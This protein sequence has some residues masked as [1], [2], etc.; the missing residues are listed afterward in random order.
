[1][2]L[3]CYFPDA[4]LFQRDVFSEIS[5]DVERLILSIKHVVNTTLSGRDVVG[6]ADIK[7]KLD[8]KKKKDFGE[9]MNLGARAS[10]AVQSTD[11]IASR[12]SELHARTS[13]AVQHL[14]TGKADFR[15]LLYVLGEA[16]MGGAGSTSFNDVVQYATIGTLGQNLRVPAL[17]EIM[18]GAD[19]CQT[20][21]QLVTLMGLARKAGVTHVTFLGDTLLSTEGQF[22]TGRGLAKFALRVALNVLKTAAET[23]S[24]GAHFEAFVSGMTSAVS[25][26]GHTDEGG[27]I[28]EFLKKSS[29]PPSCGII[30]N[31]GTEFMGLPL[32]ESIA[33]QDCLKVAVAMYLESIALFHVADVQMNGK[34]SVYGKETKT[35]RPSSYGDFVNDIDSMMVKWKGLICDKYGQH[36]DTMTSG[37]CHAKW[38]SDDALERHFKPDIFIPWFW[39]ETSPLLMD[40]HVGY[41]T[42]A[43]HSELVRLPLVGAKGLA[44]NSTYLDGKGRPRP[45]T[46]IYVKREMKSF[47]EEGIHYI[48][49][50]KYSKVGG[51]NFFK[52]SEGANGEKMCEYALAEDGETNVAAMRWVTHDNPM[53]NP[54]EGMVLEEAHYKYLYS[55]I[56]DGVSTTDFMSGEVESRLGV[57]TV[58]KEDTTAP[59]KED[60]TV[61]HVSRR[62]RR[63]LTPNPHVQV[64]RTLCHIGAAPGGAA[65]PSRE[66]LGTADNNDDMKNVI[67]LATKED[68][69]A[70]AQEVTS[71]VIRLKVAD[72]GVKTALPYVKPKKASKEAAPPIVDE[73][74]TGDSSV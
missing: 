73:G 33:P 45:G 8:W 1:M 37:G 25:L 9:D 13:Y 65:L 42:P 67:T 62:V 47:R 12:I 31:T 14:A 50:P 38:I 34:T 72:T 56:V 41:W 71:N 2:K 54:V 19:I 18:L 66:P 4:S 63:L 27:W 15:A 61:R 26:H 20:N 44:H 3:A 64:L 10:V 7:Y 49:N 22:L 48:L 46:D 53:P 58:E 74:D 6:E 21:H 28:R 39:V 17:G 24:F 68:E 11:Y 30:A 52:N 35:D 60:K 40:K 70:E 16:L 5:A 36:H 43:S 23:N 32:K 29:F 51:L 69:E 59:P 57:F 55:S